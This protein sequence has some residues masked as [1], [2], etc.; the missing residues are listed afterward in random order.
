[1]NVFLAQVVALVL[2]GALCPEEGAEV[3]RRARSTLATVYRFQPPRRSGPT[4]SIE[5]EQAIQ[6][7]V[8]EVQR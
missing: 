6:N 2:D 4:A 3:M 1:M 8:T 5:P 7:V